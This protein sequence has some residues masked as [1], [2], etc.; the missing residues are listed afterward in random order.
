MN[1]DPSP[2]SP[3]D[4]LI[5]PNQP[6]S[7]EIDHQR[8]QPASASGLRQNDITAAATAEPENTSLSQ[9]AKEGL[10]KKLQFL[11]DLSIN[12]DALVI[13]ELC[14]L[15]YM[16]CSFFRL[17][18]RWM[19]HTLFASPKTE[20]TVLVVPNYHVTAVVAP[21]LLCIFLHLISSPLE[22]GEAT[23]GYLHGGILVD[24]IGQ[25]PPSSRFT[26]VLLDAVILALQCF[27]ITVNMEKERIRNRI[28]PARASA[29][30]GTPAAV[31]ITGQDHDAEER[32]VLRDA[33]TIDE[34]N[35]LDDIEMRPL[36]NHNAI[37]AGNGEPAGRD[38]SRP[39]RGS[40]AHRRDRLEVAS[41]GLAQ[42]RE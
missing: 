35:D 30:A 39:L 29:I 34:T 38:E 37:I 20:D 42:Q 28:K 19:A 10:S 1:N 33:P 23:R 21:N 3:A 11:V 7:P 8:S 12:L 25:K 41:D 32:G 22:A 2:T 5:D 16:D 40:G 14:V 17:F 13:A 26:L 18:I 4:P 15:Y 31:P 9:S 6:H 27:L 24:F 36:E